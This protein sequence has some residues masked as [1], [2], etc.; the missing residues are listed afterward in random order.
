MRTRHIP[1][2]RK[3]AN[4][5]CQCAHTGEKGMYST[6][7]GTQRFCCK[8]CD[9]RS[10]RRKRPRKWPVKSVGLLSTIT[11]HNR[12]RQGYP[13]SVERTGADGKP[14]EERG[15]FMLVSGYVLWPMAGGKYVHN[16]SAMERK[17]VS[18][19]LCRDVRVILSERNEGRL[20]PRPAAP[21]PVEQ[22]KSVV[23]R[24]FSRTIGASPCCALE[25]QVVERPR[26]ANG[27]E[28]LP[29]MRCPCGKEYRW[30][31]PSITYRQI[32][33]D[34]QEEFDL[35]RQHGSVKVA[36]QITTGTGTV[37]R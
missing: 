15:W 3:C 26:D 37:S 29:V 5:R 31:D 14:N 25:C 16:L 6:R 33:Y 12:E 1:E 27:D 11:Y 30:Q 34:T 19:F 23:K 2:L 4:P 28:Q 10:S 36:E 24:K 32:T 35:A 7:R 21:Q 13:F 17:K 9:G 22:P 8:R 18:L 20:Q